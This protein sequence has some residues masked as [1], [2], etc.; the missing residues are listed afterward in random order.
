MTGRNS[1][2]QWR[3]TPRLG[4]CRTHEWH[5]AK[6]ETREAIEG[7]AGKLRAAGAEVAE[8]ALSE[9]FA[10]AMDA[11]WVIATLEG[12]RALEREYRDHLESMNPWLREVA[13]KA[14]SITQ[15]R[16]QA[17]L[18]HAAGCREHLAKVFSEVD[19]LIAPAS[20]GEA[21]QKLTGL[22][23][24]AFCPLWTMM[25]GPCVTIPAFQ[26]PNDMPMGLQ[27][28][29]PVCGDDRLIGICS[30]IDSSLKN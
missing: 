26:G 21:S 27:I 13:E 2:T 18:A 8:I 11:F 4:L 17:A 24:Q 23:D 3:G 9:I 5:L 1:D 28:V 14:P 10:S 12:Y 25:H 7:A 15:E 30:W 29:G 6:P 20:A 19:A 22:E 16:Y